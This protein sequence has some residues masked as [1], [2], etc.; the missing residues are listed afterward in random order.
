MASASIRRA[1]P[2]LGT[3]VDIT[4][5]AGP[6]CRDLPAAVDAA[7]AA[8]A[9]VHR[10][11]SF[12]DPASDVSRLNRGAAAGPVSVDPWTWR[13]LEAALDLNR[14]SSGAF[15]VTFAPVLQALGLLPPTG[16]GWPRAGGPAPRDAIELLP[17]G[18]VRFHHPGTR[19][20]LGGIAK[21]F[22]VDCAIE[23]LRAHGAAS[24]LVDAG[25]DI[26]AFGTAAQTIHLRDPR[27]PSLVLGAIAIRDEALASSGGRFDPLASAAA[28]LP[29][30]I[31]PQ[32]RAPARTV[33]GASVRAPTCMLADA[34]TKVVMIAGEAAGPLL[35][36][37]AA[38]ALIVRPDDTILVTPTWQ[39]ARAA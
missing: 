9:R 13:V 37:F 5:G 35:E 26:A 39:A 34:L 28:A 1:C 15:D 24:G 10:L 8:V 33:C 17:D 29:A 32:T 38:A 25:G 6:A 19:I 30:V 31:D 11:M 3:F 23:A 21:G 2:L 16:N 22:A 7:M 12:H 4:A 20:D 14:R 18:D 27:D 36:H